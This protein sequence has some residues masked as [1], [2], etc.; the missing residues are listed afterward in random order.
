V[1][2]R[3][4]VVCGSPPLLNRDLAPSL[5]SAFGPEL[6]ELQPFCGIVLF[7]WT[8]ATTGS[9]KTGGCRRVGIIIITAV[10][11]RLRLRAGDGHTFQRAG[12]VEAVSGQLDGFSQHP[13]CC[14]AKRGHWTEVNGERAAAAGC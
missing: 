9:P 8:V 2:L 13:R 3:A 11:L 4:K 6:W 1:A 7:R 12:H 5:R 14:G 10:L